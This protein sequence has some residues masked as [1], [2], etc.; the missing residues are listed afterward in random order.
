MPGKTRVPPSNLTVLERTR[1][2]QPII[3]RSC[4]VNAAFT[5]RNKTKA[6]MC[7]SVKMVIPAEVA[8]LAGVRVGDTMLVEGYADGF[9]VRK[10]DDLVSLEDSRL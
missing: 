9:W 5:R 6:N 1:R 8:K 7:Y 4:K 10:G 2:S 3:I